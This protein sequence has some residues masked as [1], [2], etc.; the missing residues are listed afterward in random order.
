MSLWPLDQSSYQIFVNT[1]KETFG[2]TDVK[3][4]YVDIFNSG[5]LLYSQRDPT[6][7]IT[8]N[9][10]ETFL[11]KMMIRRFLKPTIEH[12]FTHMFGKGKCSSVTINYPKVVPVTLRKNINYVLNDDLQSLINCSICVSQQKLSNQYMDFEFEKLL[13]MLKNNNGLLRSSVLIRLWYMSAISSHINWQKPLNS[14]I[15]KI[16]TDLF[17]RIIMDR[18]KNIFERVCQHDYD[19][20]VLVD[21]NTLCLDLDE[22]IYLQKNYLVSKE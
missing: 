14:I 2:K 15:S 9:V 13:Y 11:L 18:A 17:D 6:P 20:N 16:I 10:N 5:F 21:L 8:V 19:E 1:I 7:T 12:E 4:N 22:S 3:I